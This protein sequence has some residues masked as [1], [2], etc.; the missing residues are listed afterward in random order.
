MEAK[1]SPER[2]AS[3]AGGA[4]VPAIAGIIYG[5]IYFFEYPT[6]PRT[7][8]AILFVGGIASLIFIQTTIWV[9]FSPPGRSWGKALAAI[10]VFI[11]YLYSLFLMGYLGLWKL[12]LGISAYHGVLPILVAIFWT[13]VGWRMLFVLGKITRKEAG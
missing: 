8:A 9:F 5:V 6:P 13:S 4:I 3:L 2:H 10:S 7:T 11:P 1:L 12:W